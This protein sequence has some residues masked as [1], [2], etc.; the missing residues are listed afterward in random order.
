MST[1]IPWIY[2]NNTYAKLISGGLKRKPSRHQSVYSDKWIQEKELEAYTWRCFHS[3]I[4]THK[5]CTLQLKLNWGNLNVILNTVSK[6]LISRPACWY[7]WVICLP[8][9]TEIDSTG[10]PCRH[11]DVSEVFSEAGG[12]DEWTKREDAPRTLQAADTRKQT[13]SLF[14]DS[15]W[16]NVPG[17]KCVIRLLCKNLWKEKTEQSYMRNKQTHKTS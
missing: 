7:T 1:K 3:V 2:Y 10:L 14:M 11:L 16:L 15:K 8:L 6:I 9:H 4:L 5:I 17:T 13:Y 12:P